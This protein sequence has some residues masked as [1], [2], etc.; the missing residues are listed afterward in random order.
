MKTKKE[1]TNVINFK[2]GWI[3]LNTVG[4][5]NNVA[6]TNANACATNIETLF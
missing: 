4:Y 1:C 2:S 3:T 6:N 5:P